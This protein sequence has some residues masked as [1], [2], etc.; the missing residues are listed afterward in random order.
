M[1]WVSEVHGDYLFGNNNRNKNRTKCVN[2]DTVNYDTDEWDGFYNPNSHR[3]CNGGKKHSKRQY[4]NHHT[5]TKRQHHNELSQM[6]MYYTDVLNKQKR[7]DFSHSNSYENTNG[8]NQLM[9]S[10]HD[11]NGNINDEQ[12]H[13]QLY[14]ILNQKIDLNESEFK[15]LM[16]LLT[17]VA[18]G[19]MTLIGAKIL[20]DFLIEYKKV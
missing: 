3:L 4:D 1:A 10:S 2:N 19:S 15:D 16:K 11:V 5:E 12:Q 7:D 13:Q 14:S 9:Q 8:I 17:I 18:V 20:S 6:Q